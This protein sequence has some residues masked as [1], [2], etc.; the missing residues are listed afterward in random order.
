MHKSLKL[1]RS[2]RILFSQ[3]SKYR[4]DIKVNPIAVLD[5]DDWAG[6]G[7]LSPWNVCGAETQSRLGHGK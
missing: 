3:Y 6:H 2:A 4:A 1:R 7:R 5:L